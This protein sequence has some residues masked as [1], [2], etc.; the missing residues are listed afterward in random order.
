MLH[1]ISPEGTSA[2][3]MRHAIKFTLIFISV[4]VLLM[5]FI[6]VMSGGKNNVLFILLGRIHWF[7]LIVLFIVVARWVQGRNL[8]EAIVFE[9]TPQYVAKGIQTDK[10][11]VGNQIGMNKEARYGTNANQMIP[12]DQIASI[13]I[14]DN[15]IKIRSR[16]YSFWT[17]NGQIEIPKEV[18]NFAALKSHFV[19]L[20]RERG[21]A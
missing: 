17:S 16:N 19:N 18:N 2:F 11:N 9:V 15:S 7:L 10:L 20:K 21:I 13:T 14:S 8:A 3:G 6:S 4:F 5:L 1:K 12:Y